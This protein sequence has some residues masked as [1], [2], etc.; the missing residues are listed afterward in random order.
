MV[1]YHHLFVTLRYKSNI[2]TNTYYC[3]TPRK[4]KEKKETST[5]SFA[6]IFLHPLSLFPLNPGPVL[7][8]NR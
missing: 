1:V 7:L 4:K 3:K 5:T 2:L 6:F 8:G